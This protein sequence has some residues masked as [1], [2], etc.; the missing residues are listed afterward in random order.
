MFDEFP[1]G[2][3]LERERA[4]A[5]SLSEELEKQK[6]SQLERGDLER[7]CAH[8]RVSGVRAAD[9]DAS[10]LCRRAVALQPLAH[11]GGGTNG[12]RCPVV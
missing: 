11:R 4:R 2:R 1:K 12:K 6:V 5:D 9:T 3:Q 7:L 8:G 10:P